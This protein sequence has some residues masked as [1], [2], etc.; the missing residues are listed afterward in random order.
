[1]AS[2]LPAAA[3][4]LEP[5]VRFA[6]ILGD[7]PAVLVQLGDPS[8]IYQRFGVGVLA[9]AHSLI[10]FKVLTVQGEVLG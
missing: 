9:S 2:V 1:M 4:F 5:L 8:R 10:L 7:A 6:V 3:A